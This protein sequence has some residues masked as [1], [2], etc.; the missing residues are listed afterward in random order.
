MAGII[1][2]KHRAAARSGVG[3]VMGS[4]NLK[5]VVAMGKKNPPLFNAAEM[6]ALSVTHPKM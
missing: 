5:A 6:N 1:N 2:D 3:A 4:K